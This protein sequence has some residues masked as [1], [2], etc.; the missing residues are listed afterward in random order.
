[1]TWV[2]VHSYPIALILIAALFALWLLIGNAI[3]NKRRSAQPASP[4][5]GQDE[6]G[7]EAE[8]STAHDRR[9]FGE[10]ISEVPPD[11]TLITWLKNEFVIKYT[12]V[13][14]LNC[15]EEAIRDLSLKPIGFDEDQIDE[16]RQAFVQALTELSDAIT[17]YLQLDLSYNRVTLTAQSEDEY[18]DAVQVI[19]K[20]RNDS[21]ESY[22][23][24]YRLAHVGDHVIP[25]GL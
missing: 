23:S 10:I 5:A 11:G 19:T 17:I 4:P 7:D 13:S 1:M 3:T 9:L 22:D 14:Y 24:L 12:P 6:L 8:T 2:K 21:I 16:I 20:A 18:K 25:Q 15:L